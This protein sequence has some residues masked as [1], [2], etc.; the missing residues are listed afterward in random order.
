VSL[1]ELIQIRDSLR[2]CDPDVETFSWGPTIEFAR[3]RKDAALKLLDFE[4]KQKKEHNV[5]PE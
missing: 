1:E 5:R 2:E 4:I 3:R